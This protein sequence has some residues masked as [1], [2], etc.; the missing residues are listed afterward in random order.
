MTALDRALSWFIAPPPEPRKAR[1]PRKRSGHSTREAHP[2]SPVSDAPPP[3]PPPTWPLGAA[4]TDEPAPPALAAAALAAPPLAP[5][6]P[7]APPLA[8]PPLV[9][10]PLAPPALA[11][12]D[13]ALDRE[14]ARASWAALFRGSKPGLVDDAGVVTSAAVLGRPRDVEP[15]AAALAL[16]LRRDA[17]AKAAAVAVVGPAAAEPAADGGG[18]TAARRL[19][20]RLDAH[21][22]PARVRGRLAWVRLDPEDPQLVSAARRVTLVAAPA[23]LAVTSA[24]TAAIDEV[25]AEQDR[26]V[27]VT[28][29]PEGPLA[30][31]AAEGLPPVP[32]VFTRPL[33]RGPARAL[34]RAGLRPPRAAR[35]LV[36]GSRR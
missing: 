34:A 24:R 28:G 3:S 22:L 36:G 29:E 25:L 11:L 27:V 35:H 20:A 12:D 16:A 32:V 18:A 4:G 13:R 19:V 2:A 7:G 14:A 9:S 8:A 17:R 6:A 1:R 21:G 30:R 15:V 26:L 5:P 33:S 10:P 23:V 31:L